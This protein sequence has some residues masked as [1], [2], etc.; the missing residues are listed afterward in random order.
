MNVKTDNA[1]T[2]AQHILHIVILRRIAPDH[3]VF[4]CNVNQLGIVGVALAE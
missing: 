2:S 3:L 1:I 4:R